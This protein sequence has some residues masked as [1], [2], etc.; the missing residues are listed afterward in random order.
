M[1]GLESGVVIYLMRHGPPAQAGLLL[2]HTD[3]PPLVADCPFMLE[4]ARHVPVSRIVSS[5]LGRANRQAACLAQ[6]LQVPLASDPR[7]RE[8]DFGAWDG[9]APE[10]VGEAALSRFWNDPD[11]SPPPEGETWSRIRNRVAAA[12]EGIEAHTLVV[13]HAGAMRATVSVLTGLD[14][15]GVW[16]LDLPYRALVTLRLWPGRP[17]SGQ[18]IGLNTGRQE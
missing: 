14:H 8:L 18:V 13:T 5:D 10:V 17:L 4:R 15:R 16:A 3:V 6:H 9:L 11:A 7:W 12:L 1:S 2:G